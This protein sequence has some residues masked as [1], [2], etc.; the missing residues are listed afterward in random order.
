MSVCPLVA[1]GF[2]AI[3]III[4]CCRETEYTES[5]SYIYYN[6]IKNYII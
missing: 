4:I 3:I 5:A 1:M 6:I 2:E